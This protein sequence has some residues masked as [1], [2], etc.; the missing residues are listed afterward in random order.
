MSE[1]KKQKKQNTNTA[2]KNTTVKSAKKNI[3]AKKATI[4]FVSVFVG[5][6][7]IIGST[8]GIIAAVRNSSYVMK[9][10]SVGIDEGVANYLSSY[11]KTKYMQSLASSGINVSDTAAF[12]NTKVFNESTYGDY[13][14]YETEQYMKQI[15]ASLRVFDM[16]TSLTAEDKNEIKLAAKEIL[17]YKASADKKLFNEDTEKYGFDYKDFEKATEVLYKTYVLKERI[18]GQNGENMTS[19]PDYC[20]E[21]F[22]SYARVKLVFIRTQDTFLTD[23]EGN[24]EKDDKNNDA[25]RD[26]TESE[27]LERAE[28]IARFDECIKG[29][30]DGTVAS[31]QFDVLAEELI[32]KYGE[33][34][35]ESITG[36]YFSYGSTYTEEFQK[37]YKDVVT[38][39]FEMEI[40]KCAVIEFGSLMAEDEEESEQSF[41]GRCYLYRI[42]N[43]KDAYKNQ[44]DFF[45]DFYSL[46][47]TSLYQKMIEEYAKKVE[48]MDKWKNID[49]VNTPY[50]VDYVARF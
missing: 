3:S 20:E 17:A 27:K 37:Y 12:W 41:V 1:I 34:S 9:L 13:L 8:F 42:S 29:I 22:A 4:I 28:Y 38:K 43:E 24:R 39:T 50:N 44:N 10:E 15:I 23:A 21:Y 31:E 47:A 40:G 6:A 14:K 49:C 46:A 32:N 33:N 25:L 5:I 36:Y 7:I 11:F 48:I 18:F 45:L 19:F 35:R 2:V 26:L 16:Y 30:N